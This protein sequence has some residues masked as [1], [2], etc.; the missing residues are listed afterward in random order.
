[1]NENKEMKK[2][3]LPPY[4]SY[5]TFLNLLDYFKV[6]IPSQI[7]RTVV[8][9]MSGGVFAS[10]LC[11]LRVMKLIDSNNVPTSELEEIVN[12][13]P[14]DRKTH[15]K[16]LFNL[17]YA[18]LSQDGRS[19]STITL[20]QLNKMFSE[21]GASGATIKKCRSF[22]IAFAKDA[23]IELSPFLKRA[24]RSRPTKYKTKR[25]GTTKNTKPP[26]EKDIHNNLEIRSFSDIL[27][28]I[29]DPEVM[30]DEEQKAVWTLMLYLKKQEAI[31]E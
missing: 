24:S 1:M 18:F 29:L 28:E 30:T 27:Y 23:E 13:N 6:G 19:L 31:D 5:R 4:V 16:K 7:D 14:D 26:K 17:T 10:L 8:P 22:F 9:S 11:S 3:D 2:R 15:L 20:D 25:Q 12:S 21:N